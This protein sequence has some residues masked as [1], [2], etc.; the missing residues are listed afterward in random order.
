MRGSHVF[1]PAADALNPNTK[2]RSAVSS[3]HHATLTGKVDEVTDMGRSG[4]GVSRYTTNN[5]VDAHQ[6]MLPIL[7][8][9][10]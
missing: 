10:Q 5:Q 4:V 3:T 8:H 1:V 7:G 9:R 2:A 6:L